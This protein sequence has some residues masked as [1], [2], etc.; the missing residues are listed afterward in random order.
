MGSYYT[1]YDYYFSKEY[2]FKKD[3]ESWSFYKHKIPIN[4]Y[5]E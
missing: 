4:V 2:M 5:L 1:Q 3:G